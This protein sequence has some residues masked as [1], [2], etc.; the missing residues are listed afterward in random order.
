LHRIQA[1]R[2][3]LLRREPRRRSRIELRPRY[4][5]QKQC[6]G[7]SAT[8]VTTPRQIDLTAVLALFNLIVAAWWFF[9]GGSNPPSNTAFIVPSQSVR[10]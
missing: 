10:W 2:A 6:A 1:K 3:L 8:G 9:R 7:K 4:E 5:G